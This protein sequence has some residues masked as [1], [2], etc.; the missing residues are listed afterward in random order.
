MERHRLNEEAAFVWLRRLA[1][2]TERRLVDVATEVIGDES[3]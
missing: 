2:S 1:R 3:Q